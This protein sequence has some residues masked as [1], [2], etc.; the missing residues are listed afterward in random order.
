MINTRDAAERGIADGDIVDVESCT[1]AI[2]V[3][4]QTTT[5]LMPGVVS[6][7]HGFGHGREGVRLSVAHQRPGASYNDVSDP[8]RIDALTGNAA[9]NGQPVTVRLRAKAPEVLQPA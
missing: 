8:A 9:L 5:E 7:P 3:P 4:A 2:E 1:G 6:L